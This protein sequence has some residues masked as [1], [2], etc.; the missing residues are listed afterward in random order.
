VGPL[1][2]QSES[3]KSAVQQSS[4]RGDGTHVEDTKNPLEVQFPGRDR[5]FI[6]I[7]VIKSRDR[8]PSAPLGD[9]PLNL[10]H[11]TD[12]ELSEETARRMDHSRRQFLSRL[13]DGL[14]NLIRPL[15]IYPPTEYFA[16][17]SAG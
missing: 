6:V 13:E 17:V 14:A 11:N 4:C 12:R 10:V 9:L 2:V 7:R 16:D 5:L 15:S 1:Q 8:V 3:G